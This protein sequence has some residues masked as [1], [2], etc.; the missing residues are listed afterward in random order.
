MLFSDPQKI[1]AGRSPGIPIADYTR[2]LPE[3]SNRMLLT[4]RFSF[5]PAPTGSK[6]L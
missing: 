2:K 3:R 5:F 4:A 1:N 6:Y